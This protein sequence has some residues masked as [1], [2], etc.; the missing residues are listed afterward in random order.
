MISVEDAQKKIIKKSEPLQAE[1]RAIEKAF[2]YVLADD[3]ISPV[4]L[5]PF[6]QSAMDG[7]ALI[8]D[9]L[10]SGKKISVEGEIAAGDPFLFELQEG[11]AVR[12]FTGAGLPIGADCVVMQEKTIVEK[13]QL[14][15]N[16]PELK[17]GSNIR[18]KGSQ[19][20]SG[21]LALKKGTT[22]TAGA[23]GYLAGMGIT[24]VLVH[25]KPKISL[26]ITGNELQKP[27]FKLEEGQIYESNS[28][29]LIA[30]LNS[31]HLF[32]ISTQSV[33]D[34]EDSLRQALKK[35]LLDSDV[36]LLSG[37]IST[38]DYDFAKKVLEDIEIENIFYKV[39]QKP[40]KPLFFAKHAQTAIFALPGNPSAV[41]SCFYNYVYP[42]L[43]K[44]QGFTTYFL[45]SLKLS[46][47][48]DYSKKKGLSFF[49][50]S[51]IKNGIVMPLEGQE[52]NV[53]SSFAI[54]DSLIYLPEE[55]E[56]IKSGTIVEAIVL[57]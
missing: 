38:G 37:G 8:F 20:F 13:S 11:Q 10:I 49:L 29:S 3:V 45:P 40:G 51:K 21:N 7:Y 36:V 57:P 19:I 46:I 26:I 44:M 48:T 52:S 22:L 28:Y 33:N 23:I 14:K 42:S 50:K 6:D 25:R 56:N 17:Q 24:K 47:G 1:E 41:L 15:I 55:S 27:G 12:I 30:A 43:R 34:T 16:D 18:K 4:S 53:L 9:D 5:P 39:K 32:S 31:I 54:A 2:G 35:A